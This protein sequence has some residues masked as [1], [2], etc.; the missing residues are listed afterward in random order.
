MAANK[1]GGTMMT[2]SYFAKSFSNP[3]T[4]TRSTITPRNN[5]REWVSLFE[6]S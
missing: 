1:D 5:G 6:I 4:E 2:I 3:V